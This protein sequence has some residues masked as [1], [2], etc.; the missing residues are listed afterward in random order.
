MFSGIVEEAGRVRAA[1]TAALTIEARR[2]LEDT[3]LGDSVAVNGACLTVA[4]L[5][6]GWFG[7]DVM[8]ETLRRTNLGVLRPGDGVNL[9]RSLTL[10]SRLGGHIVQGHI[11]GRGTV[12]AVEPEGDAVLVTIAAPLPLLRYIVEKGYIAVDGASLTVVDCT[13]AAF[14]VSLVR[15][16]LEHTILGHWQPGQAV[17]LEIDILAKYVERLLPGGTRPTAPVRALEI[18]RQ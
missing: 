16:T 14:R 9:E 13:A 12:S 11:D 6:D 5:G 2:V 3:T 10:A 4:R 17:N 1:T 18:T 15:F 8:P 7:A